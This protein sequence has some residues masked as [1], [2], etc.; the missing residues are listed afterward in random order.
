VHIKNIALYKNM[1][2][3]NNS[4]AENAKITT[5]QPPLP[6]KSPRMAFTGKQ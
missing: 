6:K 2:E 1:G 3:Q 4:N 5:S